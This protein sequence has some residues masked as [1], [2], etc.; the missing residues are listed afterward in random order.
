M[1]AP[2]GRVT[3]IPDVADTDETQPLGFGVSSLA[4]GGSPAVPQHTFNNYVESTNEISMLPGDGAHRIKL[5]GL[6]NIASFG[7]NITPDQQGTYTY[8]SLA[9]FEADS[10]ATFTRA[11]NVRNTDAHAINGAVYLGDAWRKGQLQ[12]TYGA[13]V[14]G[15]L[16]GG[17]PA[18]NPV[19]DSLFHRKTNDWPSE[20]HASPRVGFTYI[21]NGGGGV[22]GAAEGE[23][24]GEGVARRWRGGG[25]GGGF[26]SSPTVIRGGIGEFRAPTPQSLFS[27]LQSATGAANGETQ[28][29][30]VGPQVPTPDWAGFANGTATPPTQCNASSLPVFPA[31]S[32]GLGARSAVTTL[33][34]RFRGAARVARIARHHAPLLPAPHRVDRRHVRP[35][36]I[37]LRRHRPQS[38][39]GAAVPARQ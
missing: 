2:A 16:Y 10:P 31:D 33:R 20:I 29:V 5:G 15:S 23:G 22:A 36:R 39:Y 18:F 37:A 13:R 7:Q 8:N 1:Q 6:I 14:E 4:F 35:R 3:V 27:S 21:L 12:I 32:L 17:A 38:R 26:F 11:F 9:A 24:E 30:C 28:L 34:A 19:I 25:G